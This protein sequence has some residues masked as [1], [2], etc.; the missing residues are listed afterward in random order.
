[1]RKKSLFIGWKKSTNAPSIRF[2]VLLTIK[3][4]GEMSDVFYAS[5][6]EL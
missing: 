5:S 6:I 2:K 3:K 1:M 4:M